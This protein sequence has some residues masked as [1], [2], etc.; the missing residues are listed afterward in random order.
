MIVTG[1]LRVAKQFMR[2]LIATR[3]ALPACLGG[4]KHNKAAQVAL[5]QNSLNTWRVRQ[6][7]VKA[8]EK[9]ELPFSGAKTCM[10]ASSWLGM[11][12][13]EGGVDRSSDNAG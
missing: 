12:E 1:I 11:L 6:T 9:G 3:W 2:F 10:P 7:Q 5:P 8:G 13:M 4:A